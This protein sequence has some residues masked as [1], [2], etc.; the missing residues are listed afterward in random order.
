MSSRWWILDAIEL[1]A[2]Q[3][4]M[5]SHLHEMIS[6]RRLED[7]DTEELEES[8]ERYISSRRSLMG[9]LYKKF[10]GDK[11][12]RC[13]FKHA[14]A[15]Y[16]YATELLEADYSEENYLLREDMYWEMVWIASK[17]FGVEP[18]PCWRCLSD[19]LLSKNIDNGLSEL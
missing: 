17:F 16:Q 3:I 18:T 12:Y 1:L 6:E 10:P 7:K 13:M 14:I 9:N 8:L 2:N 5:V 19:E 4:A 11:D 15:S